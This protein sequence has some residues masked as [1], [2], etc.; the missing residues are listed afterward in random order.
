MIT[1]KRKLSSLKEG[2]EE[3]IADCKIRNLAKGTISIYEEDFNYFI[4][5]TNENYPELD[6]QNDLNRDIVTEFVIEMQ[7][8]GLKTSTINIRLRSIR[9][10]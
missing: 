8:N 10:A 3:F 2:K 1:M 7:E 9:C 5:Y 6:I 4:K